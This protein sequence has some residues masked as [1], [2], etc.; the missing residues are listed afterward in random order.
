MG[1][2]RDCIRSAEGDVLGSAGRKRGRASSS[3]CMAVSSDC[4]IDCDERAVGSVRR[5]GWI[6]RRSSSVE[7]G[8]GMS[9][10]DE[11]SGRSDLCWRAVGAGI[12]MIL[13]LGAL[14]TPKYG[15]T[16][17]DKPLVSLVALSKK[18]IWSFP[19]Q[20]K[21]QAGSAAPLF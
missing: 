4:G 18:L 2:L 21:L 15:Q 10:A 19:T 14:T 17:Q 13:L 9:M 1:T 11:S 6:S 7:V 16:T 5:V 12:A 20:K 8:R 3:N